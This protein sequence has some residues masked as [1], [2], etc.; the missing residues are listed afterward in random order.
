MVAFICE[1]LGIFALSKNLTFHCTPGPLSIDCPYSIKVICFW[2]FF[3]E[4]SS[5]NKT[6]QGRTAV[7]APA[8]AP[9]PP[10]QH[11]PS[12]VRTPTPPCDFMSHPWTFNFHLFFLT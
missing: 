12:K 8:L 6:Q 2:R 7:E 1:A 11:Y 3:S 9:S 4:C 10:R 5:H